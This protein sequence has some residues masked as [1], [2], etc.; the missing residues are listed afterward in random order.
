[1]RKQITSIG[2]LSL[3]LMGGLA[4]AQVSGV[5]KDSNG[6]PLGQAEVTVQGKNVSVFT[7]D[8][9]TFNI[10]AKVGD[11]LKVY[12]ENGVEKTIKVTS[13]TLGEIKFT[14]VTPSTS[15]DEINLGTVNII[16]GIK[17]DPAQKV[18]S[19]TVVSREN[20]E[21]TPVSSIDEVL[22]GRVAGLNFSTASGDPGSSNMMIIRGVGSLVGTPNPLY[23]I[24]GVVVGKGADNASLMES[25]NPLASIDPNMIESVAV[26]K[27]ASATALYG[28]RGANGVIV[29]TTKKGKY[30]QKPR[31]NLSTDM[32]F[33]DISFNKIKM[34][35]AKQY[36]DYG[37]QLY[38]NSQDQLGETF[39]SVQEARDYFVRE[40]DGD[41]DGVTETNWRDAIK[42]AQSTVRT[43]NFSV[44]GGTN[45]LSYRA[46][47]TYYENKPLITSTDFDRK[48]ASVAFD[49]KVTDNIKYG[50]SGNYSGVDR[51]TI[52]DANA[53][54]N[55]W[56]SS[57]FIPTTKP[58]Y[59]ADGNYNQTNLGEVTQGFN[60]VGLLNNNYLRGKI[61]TFLGSFNA[62]FK[63][64]KNFAFHTMIGGQRQIMDELVW[65]N[66]NYGDGITYN[67]L[68]QND[69]TRIWD[70][71]T[72]QTLSFKKIFNDT[73]N[74]ELYAGIDYQDH[75][76]KL[77]QKQGRN[78]SEPIPD[79][80][81]SDPD[82][83]I[84]VSEGIGTFYKWRQNSYFG[85]LNYIFDGKYTISGQYRYDESSVLPA[86]NRGG[87]FWSVGASWDVAKEDFIG[88]SNFLSSFVFKGSYGRLGNLPFADNWGAQY[89]YYAL[90]G[91][92]NTTPYPYG[93]DYYSVIT[94]AGNVNLEWE[95]S[96]QLDVGFE[97]RLFNNKLGLTFSYYDK[98]TEGALFQTT[99]MPESGSPG[100][101]MANV[102]DISNKGVEFVLD[103]TPINKD[104][105]WDLNFNFSHNIN[106]VDKLLI[107]QEF[108]QNGLNAIAAGK[109]LGEYRT[110][111][112]AGPNEDGIGS[113]YTD[114][115]RTATTTDKSQA[116]QVWLGKSAFP[117]Y[118]AGIS[119]AFSYKGISV[120]AFFT[121]Q[122][123]FY[124]QNGYHSFFIHDGNFPG[125]NQIVDALDYWTETNTGAANPKPQLNNPNNS[126][127]D[128]DRWI[129]KGDHIRL[130]EVKIA[131]SFNS[132]FK[133]QTGVKNLTLYAK[134]TNLWTYAFDKDLNFD[135]ES[136]ENAWSFW[137]KGIFNYTTP[138][139]KSVSIG[140]SLDF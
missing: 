129:K 15:K 52:P 119:N 70:W 58:I 136:N 113:W 102:A 139:I 8:D 43:Y 5:V 140:M 20:F 50:F 28:A 49:H 110:W 73:H 120:S 106:K 94:S 48:S 101:Y 54:A 12:D 68:L 109:L 32:S 98:R 59:D 65:W 36:H 69:D 71:N 31:F 37:G 79:F 45:K 18:G 77:R 76:Y 23:V 128:S 138:I 115:T 44:A 64:L 92:S 81:Y 29:V 62:E 55:P 84:E 78:F 1:M 103:A 111:L 112:W 117:K 61:D 38:F 13:N 35:N 125:R 100:A 46:G 30:G 105:K 116:E 133:E 60:P 91:T 11:V 66:P 9:G 14:S 2:V 80:M 7:E 24:D 4:Y 130:K 40:N 132:K 63:F 118:M 42:R 131:Y 95:I 72:T 104:L 126:R 99:T 83:Y 26:L 90:V 135:P 86:S 121:G 74:L 85:R 27:D 123:D 47:L 16:G 67:G 87:N 33:Q 41:W 56:L 17:L 3:F 108:V 82:Q 19:Y 51:R 53:S 137:G 134:G 97:S 88:K 89:G 107:D 122:F 22:N 10:D 57:L 96:N 39:S 114:E 21:N 127:L 34:M 75:E 6:F 124:V 25:W 93:D